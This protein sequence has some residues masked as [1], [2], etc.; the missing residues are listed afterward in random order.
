[1]DK[2]MSLTPVNSNQDLTTTRISG[3][4]NY[5]PQLNERCQSVIE[6]HK[7]GSAI[8]INENSRYAPS[9][10]GKEPIFMIRYDDLG[11]SF[12]TAKEQIDRIFESEEIKV[13]INDQPF[14]EH[15]RSG[16]PGTVS[17]HSVPQ[18]YFLVGF[19]KVD[20][21]FDLLE[22]RCAKLLNTVKS[23]VEGTNTDEY[24]YFRN[25]NPQ[26]L[27]RY[28]DL[29][30]EFNLA[31]ICIGSIIKQLIVDNGIEGSELKNIDPKPILR[32]LPILS[33]SGVTFE[34]R[35]YVSGNLKGKEIIPPVQEP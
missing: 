12:K 18:K 13:R 7:A 27:I 19:F 23:G 33:K 11:I 25:E 26:F 2:S 17:P 30:I 15:D 16:V 5:Y 29:G 31:A 24:L 8:S 34:D 9:V 28:D 35:Q 4:P 6:L 3:L 1:M 10:A 21:A 32:T 14:E 22:K 20:S